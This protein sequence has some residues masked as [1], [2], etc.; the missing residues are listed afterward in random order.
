MEAGEAGPHPDKLE[1]IA[2]AVRASPNEAYRQAELLPPEGF[3]E[4]DHVP[5]SAL[6]EVVVR[7]ANLENKVSQLLQVFLQSAEK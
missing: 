7:M 1:G 6:D 5:L 2:K 3:A 4:P